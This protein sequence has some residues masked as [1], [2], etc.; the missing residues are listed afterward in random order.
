MKA[1]L[2]DMDGVLCDTQQYHYS[3]YVDIAKKHYNVDLGDSIKTQ[4]EGVLR[5]E[6]VK[7]FIKAVNVEPTKENIKYISELKD[8]VYLEKVEANKDNLLNDGAL[9]LLKR[10]KQRGVPIALVSASRNAKYIAKLTNIDQ[11]FDYIGDPSRVKKGKPN[12]AI[13]LM[14]AAHLAV[15]PK[16]CVVYEDAA[17]GIQAANDCGM[18]SIAMNVDFSKTIFTYKNKIADR[19][20][21]SLTDPLCYRGLYENIYDSGDDISLYIFDAG[22]VV[23]NNIHCFNDIR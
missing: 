3:C 2:F 19:Y 1:A 4:L 10:L 7:I 16:D 14:A 8:K 18:F 6:G 20:I 15:K 5:E 9:S 22:N 12:P 23:L 11:Y 17:N 13:F 21:T